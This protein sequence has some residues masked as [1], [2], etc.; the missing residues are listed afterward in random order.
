MLRLIELE[1]AGNEPI[2]ACLPQ[3]ESCCCCRLINWQGKRQ[4]KKDIANY[5]A[6]LLRLGEEEAAREAGK[7]QQNGRGRR[8]GRRTDRLQ[9]AQCHQRLIGIKVGT[10]LSLVFADAARAGKP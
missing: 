1:C 5:A 10:K 4:K 2:S 6:A 7:A 3:A 9:A 8:T